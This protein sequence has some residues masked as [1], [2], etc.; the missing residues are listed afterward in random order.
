MRQT[1]SVCLVVVLGV[2]DVKLLCVVSLCTL[3]VVAPMTSSV[4]NFQ[5]TL[6]ALPGAGEPGK[7]LSFNLFRAN[8]SKLIE[9]GDAFDTAAI[10]EI[11]H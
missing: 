3:G 9:H 2:I 8:N 10:N 1:T 11:E 5:I 7:A 6:C 4:A